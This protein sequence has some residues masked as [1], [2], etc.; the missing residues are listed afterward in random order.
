[1]LFGK[2]FE[3]LSCADIGGLVESGA[4]ESTRLE[5]KSVKEGA[6]ENGLREL[7]LKSVVG[8]L[9]SDEGRGLLILGVEG[10]E[11]AERLA[12]IPRRLL[13]DR[14]E[15]AES[16]LRNWVFSYLGSIPPALA[17]PRIFVKVFD[18]MK[19]CGLSSD[20]WIAAVYAERSQDALYYSKID[21]EAYI[22]RGSETRRLSLEEV[23]S[24]V[25]AKRKPIAVVALELNKVE[26]STLVLD[27]YIQNIGFSVAKTIAAVMSLAKP[28]LLL[29]ITPQETSSVSAKSVEETF[30]VTYV[31]DPIMKRSESDRD[32][33]F[34]ISIVSPIFLPAFPLVPYKV[35]EIALSLSRGIQRFSGIS[36]AFLARVYTEATYTLQR[37]CSTV[38]DLRELKSFNVCR[39]IAVEDYMMRK[40]LEISTTDNQALLCTI[41][42]CRITQIIKTKD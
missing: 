4:S 28:L 14:R 16:R 29:E 39:R 2:P 12:C 1:M 40:I 23:V 11:R 18:C 42:G 33:S 20:G 37:S 6:S 13:G 7:V 41:E 26:G 3:K 15:V 31:T 22:R 8:F 9:N 10:K 21:E 30:N 24:T 35:G 34:Q 36:L 38:I 32:V 19:E 27:V 5:F 25:E 17:P